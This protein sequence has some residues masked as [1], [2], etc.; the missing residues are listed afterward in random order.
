MK[1]TKKDGTK[2]C[3]VQM[4]T[5]LKAGDMLVVHDPDPMTM[6]SKPLEMHMISD[7]GHGGRAII[8]FC[9]FCGERIALSR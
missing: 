8:Q 5:E 9:P 4:S 3:C 7:G 6:Q 2:A 1:I